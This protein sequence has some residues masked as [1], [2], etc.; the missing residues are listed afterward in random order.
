MYWGFGDFKVSDRQEQG[1][2]ILIQMIT[3][4]SFLATLDR[5]KWFDMEP[6]LIC[7]IFATRLG[8]L[9][10]TMRSSTHEGIGRFHC[11]SMVLVFPLAPQTQ[12]NLETTNS[13]QV[14][15][16]SSQIAPPPWRIVGFLTTT[17]PELTSIP[18][19][20]LLFSEVSK[21]HIGKM[22]YRD[23]SPNIYKYP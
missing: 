13:K 16:S 8:I 2:I 18:W 22:S 21:F 3:R 17:M 5:W 9:A 10:R 12:K 23:H 20:F 7:S 11:P 6:H 19:C 15:I 14:F 1:H 4:L